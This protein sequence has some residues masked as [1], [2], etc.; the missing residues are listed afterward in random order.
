M[1]KKLLI[2]NRGEIVLRVARTCREM[3]I[4]TVGVYSEADAKNAHVR[5][6][7]E[8]YCIGPPAPSQSYLDKDKIIA[9]AK[10]AGADAIHP[11][12]GFLSENADFAQRVTDAGLIWVGPPPEAIRVMGD[13]IVSRRKAKELGVP[14]IPGTEEPLDDVD[15]LTK[16]AHEIGFPVLLKA[17]G[18]GGGKGIRMVHDPKRLKRELDMARSEATKAFGNSLVFMEKAIINGRHIELQIMGTPSGN[19]LHFGERDC[20]LQRRHQKVVEEAPSPIS[21]PALRE[22]L[23]KVGVTLAKGIG[24]KNA[25]TVE[26]LVDADQNVYFLEM[27]TR[28]QVEHAVT[29]MVTGVDLVRQQLRVASGLE[30]ELTQDDIHINGH[31]FEFRV[32][33]EDPYQGFSASTGDISALRLPQ[34]PFVRVDTALYHGDSVSLHYDPML[35]KLVVWARTREAALARLVRAAEDFVINGPKTS[36]PLIA[37]LARDADFAAGRFH[38]KW[39]DAFAAKLQGSTAEER[40]IAA[41]AAA[42]FMK[43]KREAASPTATSSSSPIDAWKLSGRPGFPQRF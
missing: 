6:V 29:E 33:A 20:S 8:A 14:V 28:L 27:N 10:A 3:G 13:K 15:R 4:H 42:M 19:V 11:G 39:L 25:G 22:R 12:Y 5:E 26:M 41:V 31:A 23:V 37:E 18:G 40:E 38:T 32:Y 34:G 21:S 30:P 43:S 36:L 7:D 17:S 24:Y 35:A 1:I 16:L 9:V 2:A